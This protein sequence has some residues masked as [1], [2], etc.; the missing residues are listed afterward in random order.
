V[1]VPDPTVDGVY[2]T[3]QLRLDGGPL[4]DNEQEPAGVNAPVPVLENV[5]V[6]CGAAAAPGPVSASA[7]RAVHTVPTPT[8]TPVGEQ[9]TLVVVF[10]LRVSVPLPVTDPPVSVPPADTLIVVVAAGVVPCVVAT[11]KSA[12][13]CGPDPVTEAGVNVAVAPIGRP[14]ALRLAVQFPFDLFTVIKKWT[15]SPG[16]AEA[17]G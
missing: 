13:S 8:A 12:V 11:A 16:E 7:T 5:T 3:E 6:P 17:G 9:L 10:L 1:C 14:E 2:V 4:A 15:V